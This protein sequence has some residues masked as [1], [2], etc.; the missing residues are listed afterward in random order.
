MSMLSNRRIVRIEWGDCDPAGIIFYPRYFEIVDASTVAL[1]ESALGM[2]KINFLKHY[3]FGG[4]PVVSTQARFIR[5]TRYGDDVAVDSTIVF[6]NSSFTVEHTFSLDGE[7]ACV[8]TEKRVWVVS[9][10]T[11]PAVLRSQPIPAAV[12]GKFGV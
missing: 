3:N 9:D 8:C 11:N 10:P 6:G 5:P 4:M 12:R 1:F 7:T 2:T